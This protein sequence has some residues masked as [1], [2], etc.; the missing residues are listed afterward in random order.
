MKIK[1]LV[2]TGLALCASILSTHSRAETFDLDICIDVRPTEAQ[3]P[4]YEAVVQAFS[5]MMAEAT[6]GLH[7]LGNVRI[8]TKGAFQENVHI[9]WGSV[10]S[11]PPP[12]SPG[13]SI[14][15]M[16]P[17]NGYR[18]IAPQS[19]IRVFQLLDEGPRK[20]AYTLIHEWGHYAY[21]LGDEYRGS[22]LPNDPV[23]K[24]RF[25]DEGLVFI[26][27]NEDVYQELSN[28]HGT[29]RTAQQRMFGANCWQTLIRNPKHD[30]I[31]G[32]GLRN[33]FSSGFRTVAPA[34]GDYVSHNPSTSPTVKWI[35]GV[36]YVIV[37]DRSGSMQGTRLAAAKAAATRLVRQAKI[38]EISPDTYA[39]SISVVTFSSSASA[40]VPMKQIRSQQ[41][42][43]QIESDINSI[44]ASGSTAIGEGIYRALLELIDSSLSGHHRFMFL[45]SDGEN[46]AGRPPLAAAQASADLRI[47]IFTFSIDAQGDAL[48]PQIAARTGGDSFTASGSGIADAFDQAMSKASGSQKMI[49]DQDKFRLFGNRPMNMDAGA[50]SFQVDSSLNTLRAT[51]VYRG[52]P[53]SAS[54][55]LIA[56][57][58]SQVAPSDVRALGQETL[59]DFVVHDPMPGRWSAGGSSQS[60]N[61]DAR[62]SV[63]GDV[64]TLS[65]SLTIDEPSQSLVY[66]E[67]FRISV[68]LAGVLPIDGAQVEGRLICPDGSTMPL[69]FQPAGDGRYIAEGDYCATM[70]NGTYKVEVQA[71]NSTANAVYVAED[72][73]PWAVA[74]DFTR[75]ASKEI[76][77]SE[78]RADDH[79]NVPATSTPITSDNDAV[80]GRLD[81]TAD[82]DAFG[83][84]VP[85][86]GAV[87]RVYDLG[88]GMNPRVQIIGANGGVIVDRNL[89]Q[90]SARSGYLAIDVAG[91]WAGRCYALV[92]HTSPLGRGSYRVSFG[93]RLL[94]D[95]TSGLRM[96]IESISLPPSIP[97][98]RVQVQVRGANQVVRNL[99]AMVS[100]QTTVELRNTGEEDWVQGDVILEASLVDDAGTIHSTTRT[101][102][103]RAVRVGQRLRQV[104]ALDPTQST[105]RFRVVFS[106]GTMT[107]SIAIEDA[108]M[109]TTQVRSGYALGQLGSGFASPSAFD[110][111][112]N[113][114]VTFMAKV[115]N[116]PFTA[117]LGRWDGR[118]ADG[119]TYAAAG[120]YIASCQLGQMP[121]I[122]IQCQ[123]RR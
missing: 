74:E 37:I 121:A 65:Y 49:L 22:A 95:A 92:S 96:K 86:S 7:S 20:L 68:N 100:Y 33:D 56:P 108:P 123:L 63:Y 8:F 13:N 66:P 5:D 43:A 44:T 75:S 88:H 69:S 39:T 118:M 38:E 57:D 12:S 115:G 21:G 103:N 97:S 98:G 28:Y 40:L 78:A 36:A 48:L 77:V 47:P 58:S 76:V 99:E 73:E 4:Q 29:R 51:I 120:N 61:L 50:A 87:F 104:I 35:D 14:L 10:A 64:D 53:N 55:Y 19:A 119:R 70:P 83:F 67:P 105:G 26:M 94:S 54:L 2:T 9:R 32:L 11:I 114:P 91:R 71:N 18:T 111:N 41:D 85:S 16:A 112:R 3:R 24:P 93:P 23:N 101:R 6:N 45:L 109:A 72:E 1:T 80:P 27:G 82:I 17:R 107:D 30:P 25:T 31:I 60:G 46:N 15:A 102:L 90:S 52:T 122:R 116:G 62:I 89:A 79:G 42:I 117:V 110:P 84:D 106:A 59:V 81:Y 113:G 34:L